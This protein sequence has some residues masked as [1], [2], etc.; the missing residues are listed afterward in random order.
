MTLEEDSGSLLSLLLLLLLLLGGEK[1]GAESGMSEGGETALKVL[2]GAATG[3]AFGAAAATGAARVTDGGL[4]DLVVAFMGPDLTAA[5]AVTFVM[6]MV[7][8]PYM[9]LVN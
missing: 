8:F 1:S 5:M 4:R 3:A 7:R 2:A 6:S 9:A